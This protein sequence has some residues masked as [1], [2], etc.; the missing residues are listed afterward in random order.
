[1]SSGINLKTE[2]IYR[3]LGFHVGT[4]KHYF[5][6]N[7]ELRGHK[8]AIITDSVLKKIIAFNK[9]EDFF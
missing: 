6:P 4:L 8:I 1:M 2:E 5:I 7:Q 9:N 3:Y